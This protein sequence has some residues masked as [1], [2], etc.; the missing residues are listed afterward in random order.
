[1]INHADIKNSKTAFT[2]EFSLI[3]RFSTYFFFYVFFCLKYK[4]RRFENFRTVILSFEY[5][6]GISH[7]SSKTIRKEIVKKG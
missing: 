1:M 6:T 7:S 5:S 3:N 2:R 4:V